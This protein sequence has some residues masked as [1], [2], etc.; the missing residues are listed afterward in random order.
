MKIRQTV[1]L[2]VLGTF[3]FVTA[4]F[5]QQAAQPQPAQP[6]KPGVQVQVNPNQPAQPGQPARPGVQF[7]VNPNQPVAQPA[8]MQQAVSQQS[9]AACVAI[10]NQEEVS[11]AQ[12]ASDK[13]KDDEVKEFAK[14]LVTDHQS[15]LKKLQRFT[16]EARH[17]SL[18]ELASNQDRNDRS[19]ATNAAGTQPQ[20]Q[21]QPRQPQ[22]Q[23]PQAQ[24]GRPIQQTA[25]QQPQI[26]QATSL[27]MIQLHRE[28]AQQC[29]SDAKKK[30]SK[31]EGDK[32]D[33][34]FIGHQMAM[35]GG[36]KATLTV[37]QRHSSGEFAS[38]LGEG[39]ETTD[40]HLKQ[41]EKIMERLHGDK[42]DRRV[43]TTKD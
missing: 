19:E 33:A 23:Q 32:F 11:L 17:N 30:M 8:P 24:P 26:G 21:A 40:K 27:D 39:L 28:I 12:F 18:D 35:H 4:A 10:S 29:L 31:E 3:A 41:A 42:S 14:M 22:P 13:A 20:L 1:T 6:A 34:C 36:M 25:G 9:M 16:P 7:Q 5:S 43:T 2:T 38:L 37:L 15:F